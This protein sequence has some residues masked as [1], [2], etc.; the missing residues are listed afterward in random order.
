MRLKSTIFILIAMSMMN[1][2]AVTKTITTKDF[3]VHYEDY[4][5]KY[6]KASIKILTVV[7]T[8]A[9]KMGFAF[10][11]KIE[12]R[13]VKSNKTILYVKGDNPNLITWEFQSLNDFLAPQESKYNNVYALCHEMGHVCMGNITPHYYWMTRDYDEGWGNYFGS[14]MIENVYKQLGLK[15]WPNQHDYHKMSGIKAFI[16]KI[17]SDKYKKY[18]SFTYCSLFWYNLS[19][20][21]GKNNIC[22]FMVSLKACNINNTNCEA[23]F[24]ETLKKYKLDS[25]FIQNF[26]KNKNYLLNMTQ[27]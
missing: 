17:Q 26:K 3:I 23:K 25:E 19:E 1:V 14:L 10:P 27:K 24:T 6:A 2:H 11:K 21:I 7:K 8:N 5:E 15:A 12:F 9:S 13:I 20:R 4:T 22:N 18:P 16:E